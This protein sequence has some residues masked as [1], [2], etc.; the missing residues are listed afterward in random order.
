[1]HDDSEYGR[2]LLAN[3]RY[4]IGSKAISTPNYT[5]FAEGS[6]KYNYSLISIKNV[7]HNC[8]E[9][10]NRSASTEKNCKPKSKPGKISNTPYRKRASD[11][12]RRRAVNINKDTPAN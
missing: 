11:C 7:K 5:P 8:V 1:M 12:L 2:Y 3:N 9:P 10:P 4:C 6:G